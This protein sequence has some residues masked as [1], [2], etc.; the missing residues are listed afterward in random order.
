MQNFNYHSHTY[1]CV[2]ADLD[3]TDE[4]YILDYI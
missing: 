2:H 1:R 4:E 3:Y